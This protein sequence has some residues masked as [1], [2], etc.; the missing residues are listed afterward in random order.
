M[1]STSLRRHA[2]LLLFAVCAGALILVI[3]HQHYSANSALALEILV[4][5]V[6][7]IVI[8][9]NYAG[10]A[11]LSARLPKTAGVLT[12]VALALALLAI[13]IVIIIRTTVNA[14]PILLFNGDGTS[15][16]DVAAVERM[17]KDSH[18]DYST[19][20]TRQL[21]GMSQSQLEAY[22]LLIVPGGNFIEMGDGL[23]SRTTANIHNAVQRGMNYLGIC[24]GAFLAAD[25]AYKSLNLTSGTR[26]GFYSAEKRGVRK[27]AV[28]IS[29]VAMPVLDHYWEDGPQLSGW[30]TVVGKYPDGTPAIVERTSGKG[31]VILSGVH[32]EAPE[33][34]RR[35]MT[36]ATPAST[37][38]A[39]A[40]TLIDAALHR[41]PL[42]HY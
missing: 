25:G 31:W 20:D 13:V 41:K 3:E 22:R 14:P 16:N 21:N 12:A 10:P 2:P 23:T 34:W 18:L 32:A 5:T 24:A 28:A 37:D 27:A 38:N 42:P 36:F 11:I 39:Y 15:A 4:T 7:A 40:R 1:I 8:M 30:G 9:R 35:G 26:F 17:L 19:V 6:L 33:S 29:T